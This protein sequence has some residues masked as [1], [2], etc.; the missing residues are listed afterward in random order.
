M[1]IILDI[2]GVMNTT[3]PWKRCEILDD[4]FISFNQESVNN[5]NKII[6]KT[7]AMIAL[8]SS[9]KDS[10]SCSQWLLL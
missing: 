8:V 7:D 1:T 4:G 3:P 6:K 2:D 9:H 10:F 5:L